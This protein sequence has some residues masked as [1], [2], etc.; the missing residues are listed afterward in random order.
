MTGIDRGRI[1][2][3]LPYQFGRDEGIV[4]CDAH[5][6]RPMSRIFHAIRRV[7]AE[8]GLTDG[9]LLEAYTARRDADAFAELVRRHGPMVWGVCRR[10]LPNRQDAEDAFQATFLVLVRKPEAVLPAERIGNW[11]HGVAVRAARKAGSA[12][13]RRRERQAVAVPEPA[14]AGER[15]W[16]DVLPVLDEEVFLLPARYRAVIVL[17][18]LEGKTRKEAARQLDVPEGTVA[19]RLARARA[20][21]GKRLARRGACTPCGAVAVLAS[22]RVASAEAPAA[23]VRSTNTAATLCA[24]GLPGGLPAGIAALTEGVVRAMFMTKLKTAT[25]MALLL[26]GLVA[27]GATVLVGPT[28]AAQHP[29]TQSAER[30]TAP[31]PMKGVQGERTATGSSVGYVRGG[32]PEDYRAEYKALFAR[33]LVVMAEHFETTY[34]EQFTGRIDAR[35]SIGNR[36]A[37]AVEIRRQDDGRLAVSVKVLQEATD[38]KPAGRDAE[39]EL[40]ILRR[41]DAQ[42]E[43]QSPKQS[44]SGT[45]GRAKDLHADDRLESLQKEVAE[46]REKVKA[47]EKR[48]SDREEEKR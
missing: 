28:A 3:K 7:A 45:S 16:H 8:T 11:L 48:L 6:G 30:P 43:D 5:A 36:K 46:L 15:P 22:V 24:A 21:L 40:V 18:D 39:L 9:Q 4:G 29:R 13:A 33:T 17:C 19:G 35:R 37:A 42:L 44:Q 23:V 34:A 41:L 12:G 10:M 32:R 20:L 1:P 2:K 26:L 25:V 27:S 31:E 47:L 14:T 38:G